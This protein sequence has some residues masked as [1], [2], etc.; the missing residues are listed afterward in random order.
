MGH[1]RPSTEAANHNQTEE[2]IMSTHTPTPTPWAEN[3]LIIYPEDDIDSSAWIADCRNGIGKG[4]AAFIVRACNS[5]AALV[6][7]LRECVTETPG[8]ACYNT[9]KKTRRLEAINT[10]VYAALKLAE[11]EA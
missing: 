8:A 4:N 2:T 11:G 6:A 5:H 9:G 10:I 7:A 3:D 1:S